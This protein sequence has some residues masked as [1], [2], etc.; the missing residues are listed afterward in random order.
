MKGKLVILVGAFAL[1][2]G[3][4]APAIASTPKDRARLC[5]RQTIELLEHLAKQA[6]LNGLKGLAKASHL[7]VTEIHQIVEADCA[8]R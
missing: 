5:E 4:S 2:F 8:S 6:G 7:S 3:A 1:C